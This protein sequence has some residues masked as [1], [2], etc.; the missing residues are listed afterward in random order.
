MLNLLIF[1]VLEA[2][3]PGAEVENGGPIGPPL[4]GGI[5]LR[6]NAVSDERHIRA[7]IT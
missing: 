6:L 7:G 4:P 5:G 3:A 1:V 2:V